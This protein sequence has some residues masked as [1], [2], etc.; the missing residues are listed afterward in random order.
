MGRRRLFFY[1][2]GNCVPPCA[3]FLRAACP[4]QPAHRC[5]P[6]IGSAGI[7][8]FTCS[9]ACGKKRYRR[10]W[11]ATII[12]LCRGELRSPLRPL[13]EGCVPAPACT[14]MLA[15]NRV[16]GNTA[17]TCS[18]ACGKKRYRR[19]WAATIISLCRGELRS[20]LRPLPEGRVPAPACTQVLACNRVCRDTGVYVQSGLRKK[21]V[22]PPLGGDDRFYTGGLAALSRE[23]PC[24]PDLT[25]VFVF[26]EL[27]FHW[28][29]ALHCKANDAKFKPARAPALLL[30]RARETF[31]SKKVSRIPFLF[32]SSLRPS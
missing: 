4:L 22:S 30:G 19:L 24:P 9:L 21:T 20:P 15:C 16:C 17:F 3:P 10:F 8:A 27:N 13:P 29:P 12:S 31:F 25:E 7:R 1:A 18:L 23:P 32:T 26:S 2:G 6:A 14:Q 28:L 11:A 5:L